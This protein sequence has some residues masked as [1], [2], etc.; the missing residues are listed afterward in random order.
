MKIRLPLMI[1]DPLVAGPGAKRLTDGWDGAS[2]PFYLDGPVTRRV[3]VLDFDAKTAALRGSTR[4][5]PPGPRRVLAAYGALDPERL[6]QDDLLR[7]TPFTTVLKTLDLFEDA[8]ALGHPVEWAFGAQQLLVVPRAG[9]WANAF[10]ERASHSLQFFSFPSPTQPDQL[11]HTA[12]SRDIVAHE[13][14]HA[15]LDGVVPDLY[16][17]I[18]PQSLALHEA[19][20]D[21]SALLLAFDS[22]SLRE[23]VLKETQGSIDK[24]S[25][26]SA[27]GKQVGQALDRSGRH[28]ASLRDLENELTLDPSGGVPAD[29]P[30]ALS[31]VLTGAL[32]RV[33]VDIHNTLR[34]R[35]AERDGITE[36]SASGEALV[37][38]AKRFKHLFLGAL[39][40]LPPGEVS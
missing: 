8:A 14:G 18:S 21:L 33:M 35:I 17:A 30:H 9:E 31:E 28:D 16:N 37:T 20:A 26:F 29:D 27:I 32:Y 11:I 3:A 34:K 7:V 23:R 24:S 5:L 19:I 1:Q 10:Y 4:F 38:G 13:T 39:D 40:Y 15:I 36:Y 25:A 12:L 6:S 22:R 2:E